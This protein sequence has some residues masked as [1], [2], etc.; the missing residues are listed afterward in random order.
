MNAI[1]TQMETRRYEPGKDG[2]MDKKRFIG[3]K[4]KILLFLLPITII[5]YSL[6]CLVT[7]FQVNREL[8][9][10]LRTEMDL[11]SQ[12]VD[13]QIAASVSRTIGIMDN[14]KKSIENGALDPESVKA[15]LYTVADAYPE[16]IPTGIYCGLE[17]GTYIDKTW[18]PDDPEWVMKERPWYIEGMKADEVTFGEV[19]LDGMTG[20]YIASVYTNIK[21]TAGNKVGVISADIP[22]DDIAQIAQNQSLFDHGYVYIVDSYSDM[23][24]G[25]G[26]EADKNGQLIS[27]MD[28]PL[29]AQIAQDI[30]EQ[31][32]GEICEC[33]DTYYSL[34]QVSGT[35]FVTVSIVPVSDISG[36]IRG[37]VT[38]TVTASVAGFIIQA[39]VIYLL[40]T[41]MLRP[42]HGISDMIG[43]MY[44]L[45]MTHTLNIH[46]KDEFG[47]IAGQLNQLAASLRQIIA[48]CMESTNFLQEKAENNLAGAE[49]ITENSKIQQQSMEQFANTMDDLSH[50]IEN[51]AEGATTLAANVNNVSGNI[52]EVNN[53]I[54]ETSQSAENG[55]QKMQQMKENIQSVSVSSDELQSAIEDVKAGLKGI[56]EMVT[57]IEGIASQTN[58]LSLNANIEAARAGE[59]GKGFAVVAGEIRNLADSSQAS[60]QKIIETTG[61][62][63]ELVSV[64]I[65]KAQNNIRLIE[66]S[67]EEAD[68]VSASFSA[69]HTNIED[70]YHSSNEIEHEIKKVDTIASDMAATTQEQTASVEVVLNTCNQMMDMAEHVVSSAQDLG[71]AGRDL[72]SISEDLKEQ[73]GRFQV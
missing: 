10:N 54:T 16:T 48:L 2:T 51:V 60:V 44:R 29:S 65:E 41:I 31:R 69:I 50:A 15:Y 59:M 70:I 56:N 7:V 49:S 57:V 36:V 64:V 9:D 30:S 3:I 17:D 34:R 67:K 28:D 21:D 37:L 46:Q 18:V 20:S 12:I 23:I 24:F 1:R 52:Y 61:R 43:R 4:N 26:K 39:V 62:L 68:L 42:L 22:I 66:V 6:V 72:N 5:T 63:D 11:T 33:A 38:K 27:D 58:L 25:N 14:V 8:K 45:D 71:T 40:M 32:F 55:I 35:N 19:Y 13:G 53:R 47:T 73:V